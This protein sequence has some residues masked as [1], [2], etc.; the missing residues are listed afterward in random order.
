MVHGPKLGRPS[1]VLM[2][3][4]YIQRVNVKYVLVRR[5]VKNSQTPV[6]MAKTVNTGGT[7]QI[8][9]RFLKSRFFRNIA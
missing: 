3:V 8:V 1:L 6:R 4:A 5:H 9:E 2:F 7:D